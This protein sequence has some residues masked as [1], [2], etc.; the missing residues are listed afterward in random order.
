VYIPT[1]KWGVVA[2]FLGE[3]LESQDSTLPMPVVCRAYLGPWTSSC[4]FGGRVWRL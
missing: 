1:P 3:I 4:T 2:E